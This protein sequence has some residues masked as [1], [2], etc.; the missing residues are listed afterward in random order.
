MALSW[1]G[2]LKKPLDEINTGDILKEKNKWM[3]EKYR[4]VK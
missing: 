3:T 4:T 2:K 1:P